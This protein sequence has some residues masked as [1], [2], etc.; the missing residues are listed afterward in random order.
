MFFK[1]FKKK[2][3]QVKQPD[4]IPKFEVP[5]ADY[6]LLKYIRVC[7]AQGDTVTVG[8]G[9]LSPVGERKW[10]YCNAQVLK[11]FYGFSQ[12]EVLIVTGYWVDGESCLK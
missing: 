4:P 1:F 12:H 5:Q 2:P 7:A 3:Q 8:G 11:E 10:G 6:E 9:N